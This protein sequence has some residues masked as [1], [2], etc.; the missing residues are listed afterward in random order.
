MENDQLL[1]EFEL[2]EKKTEEEEWEEEAELLD[3]LHKD[4]LS[5]DKED[6]TE[7]DIELLS[8]RTKSLEIK[9]NNK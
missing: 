2:E 8:R 3:K 7:L 6:V 9:Y 5:V 4:I 1:Q